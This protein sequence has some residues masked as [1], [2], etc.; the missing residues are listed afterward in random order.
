MCGAKQKGGAP[1]LYKIVG[2]VGENVSAPG[3]VL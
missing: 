3:R 1:G 2:K